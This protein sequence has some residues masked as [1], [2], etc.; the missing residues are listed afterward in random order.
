[1]K[2]WQPLCP[3]PHDQGDPFVLRV[4]DEASARHRY[5]VYCT[6]EGG[7]SDG[8]F[9]VFASDDLETFRRLPKNALRADLRRD[10]WAPCVVFVPKLERPWVMLYSRA[11]G[12]GERGHVGHIIRRADA[13]QPEG[14]FLDSGEELTTDFD[15]AIDPDVF[16]DEHDRAIFAFAADYTDREPYG[17]GLFL[18]EI[19]R[20]LRRLV[21]RPVPFA[22]PSAE[23][24]VYDKQRRMPWKSIA[25]VDWRRGDKVKWHCMEGPCG[26][27]LTPDGRPVLLYSGGCF[28]G[29]YAVG[30]I[31][32]A[33]DMS[34]ERRFV[35]EPHPERG[36]I[37]VGHTSHTI[38]PDFSPVLF[39]HG[40]KDNEKAPRQMM[41]APLVFSADGFPSSPL[42]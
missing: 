8:A 33:R 21:E 35:V 19:S 41:C 11:V 39:F 6:G 10:H 30:A 4:P 5:Y 32:G 26:G 25:G 23:W 27:L 13:E 14:P 12:T 1:M 38:A 2:A 37:S 34:L 7:Q 15:F 28:F 16:I 22:R 20:D 40:R 9:Q 3:S 18:A 42:L 36:I 29:F 17:T 24:H 31:V